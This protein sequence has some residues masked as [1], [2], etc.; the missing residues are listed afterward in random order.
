MET[1]FKGSHVTLSYDGGKKILYY[2]YKGTVLVDKGI[3]GLK[4]TMEFAS[5]R[6]VKGILSDLTE[7]SGSF[8]NANEFLENE[9]YPYMIQRG[10][11]CNAFVVSN[12][13]FTKFATD[14]LI[15]RM[16]SFEL[17]TFN[18]VPEAQK[19]VESKIR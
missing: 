1:I 14:Q 15:K 12:N 16:G 19:W 10:L 13:V 6:S 7:M 9:Y 2:E 18:N 11:V 3:E 4:K 8:T 5:K 17:R